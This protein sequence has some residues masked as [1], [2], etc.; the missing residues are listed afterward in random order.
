MDQRAKEY[1]TRLRNDG[2]LIEPPANFAKVHDPGP[3]AGDTLCLSSGKPVNPLLVEVSDTASDNIVVRSSGS[4]LEGSRIFIQGQSNI[5]VI[6]R[7]AQ[8]H[9]ADIRIPGSHCFFY[10]GAMSITV[11]LLVFLA[12]EGNSITIGDECILS[13][14]VWITNNDMHSIYDSDSGLRINRP[15]D[16]HV[17]SRCWLGR[18]V[19]VLKGAVV[20]AGVIIGTKS[21]VA[22]GR[23]EADSIYGGVPA[24]KLRSGVKWSIQECDSI[25]ELEASPG[26]LARQARA[27]S[28]AADAAWD[29]PRVM[30]EPPQPVPV[31]KRKSPARQWLSAL[32]RLSRG[33][34]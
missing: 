17:G 1:L 22:S 9:R 30:A 31:E 27:Q 15:G 24:R 6:G 23:L 4:S 5:V 7:D 25:T 21:L 20:E 34:R 14:E 11:D 32:R 16:I 28:F 18:D 13:G 29:G 33:R 12:G 2:F 19:T 10:F 26:W 8:L 3:G